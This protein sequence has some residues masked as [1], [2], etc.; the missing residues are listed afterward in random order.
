[1]ATDEDLISFMQTV[2]DVAKDQ[3]GWRAEG[4]Q[5]MRR[6]GLDPS[7]LNLGNPSSNTASRDARL[8]KELA[9]RCEAM[10]LITKKA[11]HYALVALTDAGK[12]YVEG[13]FTHL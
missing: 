11:N 9:Q 3:S 6:L 5:I 13:G 12:R 7:D 10:D 4:A 2:Y 1:M 8:Y